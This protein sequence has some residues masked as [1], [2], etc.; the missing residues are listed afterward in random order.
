MSKRVSSGYNQTQH[1]DEKAEAGGGTSPPVTGGVWGGGGRT[2]HTRHRKGDEIGGGDGRSPQ[3]RS[4]RK[5]LLSSPSLHT[6]KV[7]TFIQAHKMIT[8]FSKVRK[9]IYG[10]FEGKRAVSQGAGSGPWRRWAGTGTGPH[11]GDGT[12]GLSER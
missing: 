12:C 7:H 6:A 4:V 10:A 5:K 1:K 3:G 2:S 8:P 11:C 9:A